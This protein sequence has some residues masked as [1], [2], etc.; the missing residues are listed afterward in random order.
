MNQIAL[1]K[2][3]SINFTYT[4]K[5]SQSAHIFCPG[6]NCGFGGC[7]LYSGAD[8]CL[9]PATPRFGDVTIPE[10]GS[11]YVH[12]SFRYQI[13]CLLFILQGSEFEF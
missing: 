13:F 10:S 11:I 6:G 7:G 9:K 8:T 4:I 12:S 1:K 3:R 5:R 2:K